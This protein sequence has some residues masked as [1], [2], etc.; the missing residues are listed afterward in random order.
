MADLR[1][2]SIEWITGEKRVTITITQP[3]LISRVMSLS[4]KYPDEVEIVK[5]NTDGTLLAH[6]PLSY[7]KIN[8]VERKITEEQKAQLVERLSN[9]RD[10]QSN[11]QK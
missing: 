6:I 10:S 2:N 3:R 1:E 11:K 8:H 5:V 9:A 7:I 4:E